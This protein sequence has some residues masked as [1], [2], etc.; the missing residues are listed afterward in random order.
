MDRMDE[1]IKKHGREYMLCQLAEECCELAQAALKLVRVWEKKTPMREYEARE[2]LI[3]E[4]ADVQV[5]AGAVFGHMLETHEQESV[6]EVA[7]SKKS[8][9]FARMLDGE[10]EEDVW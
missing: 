6:L 9:M 3:E 8:R 1:I 5:M 7:E 10:M 2:H 4:L